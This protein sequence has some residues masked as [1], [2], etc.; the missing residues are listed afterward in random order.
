MTY[1]AHLLDLQNLPSAEKALLGLGADPAGVSIMG[2]KSVFRV[3]KLKNVP[4]V[5]ANILKQEIL[6]YGGES[7]NAY[8]AINHSVEKT[9]VLI[10]AT[11]AQ[12]EKLVEKLKQHQ[13]GLPDLAKEIA[14][15]LANYDSPPRPLKIGKKEFRFG[16]RTYIMGILNVT[17]DSFSDGGKYRTPGEAAGTAKKMAAEGADIIDI[18]GQSSRPG[19]AEITVDEEIGRVAPV[20]EELKKENLIISVDTYRSKVAEAALKAG[21]HLIN[22]ISGLR[23]DPSLAQVCAKYQAPLVLMHIQGTPQNMQKAPAYR[24]LLAEIIDYLSESVRLAEKAGVRDVIVDPGFGFG[25]TKEHNLEI[26]KNLKSFRTL[27]RPLLIGTSRKSTIGEVLDLP[28]GSRM[29]GTSATIAVAILNGV[30]I[31]RVHDVAEMKQT[32][33]MTDAI[34]RR[35]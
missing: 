34:V 35:I 14:S 26:L 25:K 22:D 24:D 30:D 13:F 16:E 18:G 3:I 19:S 27:G 6:S 29:M 28:V 4:P 8:G 7:A 10:C 15:A 23:F 31:I 33:Q 20:I 5:A 11:L 32:A 1:S 17:P 9:D 2:P 12:F 21:A